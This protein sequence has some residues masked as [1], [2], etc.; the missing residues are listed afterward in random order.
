[1]KKRTFKDKPDI[2]S[3]GQYTF[4]DDEGFTY[5]NSNGVS[6]NIFDKFDKRELYTRVQDDIVNKTIIQNRLQPVAKSSIE[7]K[8]LKIANSGV[9]YDIKNAKVHVAI[10]DKNTYIKQIETLKL[11]RDNYPSDEGGYNRL[12]DKIGSSGFEVALEEFE[13]TIEQLYKRDVNLTSKTFNSRSTDPMSENFRTLTAAIF[14]TQVFNSFNVIR[15][16]RWLLENAPGNQ[17]KELRFYISDSKKREYGEGKDFGTILKNQIIM[18]DLQTIDPTSVDFGDD[19]LF[20]SFDAYN[21]FDITVDSSYAEGLGGGWDPNTD[22]LQLDGTPIMFDKFGFQDLYVAVFLKGDADRWW[23]TDRRKKR[24]QVFKFNSGQLFTSDVIPQ[25]KITELSFKY[26]DS[27]RKTGD[28]GNGAAEAAAWKCKSLKLKIDTTYGF[29]NDPGFD[30]TPFAV[31]ISSS[32][33]PAKELNEETLLSDFLLQNNYQSIQNFDTYNN[34][35]EVYNDELDLE[36]K[37]NFEPIA[38]I[39]PVGFNYDLQAYQ[40]SS[41]DRQICSAPGEISL[42]FEIGNYSEQTSDLIPR[43][44]S[45]IDVVTSETFSEPRVSDIEGQS[46]PA[47]LATRIDSISPFGLPSEQLG[48]PGETARQ[49]CRQRGFD[50]GH[51]DYTFST[52]YSNDGTGYYWDLISLSWSFENMSWGFMTVPDDYLVYKYFESI[53]CEK[54]TF[55]NA[56]GY[57]FYV[58]SWNDKNNKFK[59]PQNYFDDIPNELGYL[60]LKQE[61]NLYKISEIGEPLIH[62]YSTSGI[63]TIKGVLFSYTKT[64]KKQIVRWKFFESKIF[65]DLPLTKYPDFV[66]L[67]GADYTVIPWPYTTP[68]IGGISEDSN[69][70]KSIKNTLGGGK[71][72][73]DELVNE[74]ILI[75]A[76]SNDELGESILEFDLEQ[77]RY[78]NEPYSIAD[79]LDISDKLVNNTEFTPHNSSYWDGR[80][81]NNERNHCFPDESSVGQIF[82]GDNVDPDIKRDC[83]LELNTG[84]IVNKSIY[85]S[86]GNSNKGLIFGDYKIKKRAK[87]LPISRDTSIKIPKV[88]DNEDGAL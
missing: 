67:G 18:E 66:E 34:V 24:V 17:L 32:V 61:E 69:Y 49:Y 35:G 85:D 75:D 42:D 13:Q 43:N 14:P 63:K 71:I 56:R 30:Y 88:N 22:E 16:N 6:I 78:F 60:I 68:V 80:D 62:G 8:G 47:R 86:S 53:T 59:I 20:V 81:W 1:M 33:V 11:L 65:L 82:I 54:S 28:G 23:G 70:K 36:L 74:R 37:S 39:N 12:N 57:K 15:Y 87:D 21:N 48:N 41:V 50:L 58:V 83:K 2:N 79:L 76:D 25:G 46:N 84:E 38:K 45:D 40:T 3:R 52:N 55:T 44:Y 5:E 72:S 10:F 31:E 73:D 19:S 51:S 64:G 7:I 26:G 27:R 4:F 77:I 9:K 29:E